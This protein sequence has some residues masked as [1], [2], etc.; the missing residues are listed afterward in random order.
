MNA[1]GSATALAV[2][3]NR[4]ST[5][6]LSRIALVNTHDLMGGAERCSYDLHTAFRQRGYQT[7]LIVGGKYGTD[8]DVF[9]IPFKPYEWK[10]AGFL[11]EHVGLT[12]V[13]HPTPLLGCFRWPFLRDAQ[14]VNIH[15]MHG[16]F[17]NV[18]TL[19]PLATTRPLVLTLHD[20]YNLTGDCCYTQDC[21]RWRRTCG[22]CPRVKLA[23]PARYAIG[24]R[25]LT[26]VNILIK[27]AVFRWPKRHPVVLVSPSEWLANRTRESPN[28]RHLPVQCIPNG[29]DLGFWKPMDQIE[30]RK[31][32]NLPL[33][34]RM[35]L[36]TAAN[37]DD[38]RKGG[39]VLLTAIRELPRTC[40]MH[41]V[42]AGKL[43]ER[44]K[45][46]IQG[47]PVT[48]LG[49]IADKAG[50][51]QLY[52]AA[53]FTIVASQADNLPYTCLESMACGR[54]VLG[55]DAGGIPEMI[56]DSH[57]GWRTP[58]P[59]RA[60]AICRTL[61]EIAT[62]PSSRQ[63]EMRAACRRFIETRFSTDHMVD[64]YLLLFHQLHERAAE[65]RRL[66]STEE[67]I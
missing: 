61:R 6:G 38:P 26:R 34:G 48:T 2:R 52:A 19:L 54:P 47:L 44:V 55:S 60:S 35:A 15:N 33:T 24:G 59:L 9:K 22:R 40:R 5:G 56:R 12:E 27:R 42:L 46:L 18:L 37:L 50:M 64:R 3:T 11:R 57:M 13:F 49:H 7:H 8:A 17:W 30:A 1:D 65:R 51:V 62:L 14:V 45:H 36:F 31:R 63:R 53:D 41:F 43:D 39:E 10:V 66:P 32:W 29:I 23:G 67:G 16:Q 4:A 20:E 25:D 28:L 21:E 58:C